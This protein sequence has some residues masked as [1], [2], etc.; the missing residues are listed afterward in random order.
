[1]IT[2]LLI[3]CDGLESKH[4]ICEAQSSGA[5]G[6]ERPASRTPGKLSIDPVNL[7][8]FVLKGDKFFEKWFKGVQ[9]GKIKENTKD[10]A[11]IMHDTE[12]KPVA[13][14]TISAA[15]PSKIAYTDFDSDS[16]DALKYTV[17]LVYEAFERTK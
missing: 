2:G 17:T 15:W 10:G 7:Q 5:A 13:E 1:V 14:W 4:E 9:D 8:L 11:I 3:S 6:K 16:N 12:G